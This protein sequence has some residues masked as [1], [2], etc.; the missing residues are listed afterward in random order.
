MDRIDL[1]ERAADALGEEIAYNLTGWQ[2]ADDA[3]REIRKIELDFDGDSVC[4]YYAQQTQVI[5][6]YERDF[7][8][9][10]EEIAGEETYKASHWQEAK[11]AYAYAI[12]YC[13]FSSYAAEAREELAAAV[14]EFVSDSQTELNL[15]D[16]PE[17]Q[18]SNTC[19]HGWAAHDRELEDG[20]MIFESG[21][22]DGCNGTARDLGPVWVSTCVDPSKAA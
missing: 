20:T 3:V 16:A 22:L 15:E 11:T 6:D 13:A 9:E 21:Q 2:D 19:V 5:D 1:K 10:A 7:G 12:A 18:F 17:I 8:E 4:P 14:E